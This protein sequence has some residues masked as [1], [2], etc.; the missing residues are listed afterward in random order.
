M[1]VKIVEHWDEVLDMFLPEERDIYFRE[2]YVRL[3]ET[4]TEK[5][6]CCMVN[7]GEQMMLFPFLS[8][9]FDYQ[10]QTLALLTIRDRHFMTLKQHTDMEAPFGILLMKSLRLLHYN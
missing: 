8:R 1:I 7:D 6:V 3:Y 5:A 9:T 10:G 2:E 4:D